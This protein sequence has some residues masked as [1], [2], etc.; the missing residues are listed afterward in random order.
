MRLPHVSLIVLLIVACIAVVSW[1]LGDDAQAAQCGN[2]VVEAGEEC[3]DGNIVGMDGCSG[4]CQFEEC[5]DGFVN[6]NPMEEC[7]D[8]NIVNGDGCSSTC[9]DEGGGATGGGGGGQAVC[10]NGIVE[11]G[12]ECD[13]VVP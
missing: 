12:E 5:G 10:G 1:R 13:P 3:D 7:D 4:G 11:Q 6:N 8:G 2:S 9:E